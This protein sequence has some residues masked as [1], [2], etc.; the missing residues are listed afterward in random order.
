MNKLITLSTTTALISGLALVSGCSSDDASPGATVP[1]NAIVI[2]AA[3]AE[4]T[5]AAAI[6]SNGVFDAALGVETVSTMAADDAMDVIKPLIIGKSANSGIDLASGVAY[7]DTVACSNPGGTFSYSGNETSDGDIY[8]DTGSATFVNCTEMDFTINGSLSF[9]FTE[10]YSTGAYTD[11]ASGSLSII[12]SG[13]AIKFSFNGLNFAENGNYFAGTYTISA[14]TYSVDFIVD[15]AGSGG[16]L[17][18][19]TAPIVESSGGSTSCPESGHITVTGANGSTAEGIY[20]GGDSMTIKANGVVVEP[21][22]YCY[23]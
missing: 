16:F 3:N 11:N 18:S 19:L 17:V 23:R 1:A 20:N 9:S 2:D 10:N 13:E 15:G 4:S 6:S 12:A 22:A 7:G 21:N 8:S 5:V 14:M